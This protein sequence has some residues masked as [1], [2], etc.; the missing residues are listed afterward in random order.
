MTGLSKDKF[1]SQP[2]LI[3]MGTPGFAIPALK[4]LIDRGYEIL[5][6]VTQPDRPK[7]RGRRLAAPPVKE[8]A[9]AHRIKVLQPEKA[10]DD[11]FCDLIRKMDPDLIIVV[12][13]GQI[14][15]KNFLAI[16]KWGVINIH[17]SLLPKYRGA[18]PIQWAILNN[19]SKTGLT[20]M[21]MDEGLDTGPIL[22]QTELAILKDETAG[23]LHDRLSLLAGDMIV[24][25]L[26]DM[27]NSHVKEVLQDDSLA[28][29]ASKIERSDSL[30]D[31]NQTAN[32]ISC[33]IRALDPRPGAYTLLDGKEI[34]LFSSTVLDEGGLDGVPGRVVR[35]TEEGIH[36][37]AGQGIIGIREIQY[38]GKKR[39]SIADFLR[40]FSL[41]EGTILGK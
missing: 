25:T 23:Q 26:T 18:A 41:S 28:T 22:F 16:P 30:I 32:K 34:K 15:K 7:G 38:P 3:F 24:K 14:L 19:E 4:A 8:L 9:V 10:S 13:F 6:V 37:E 39:L 40:G 35:H 11:Q 1:P 21:R 5:T 20:V 2:R 31:W 17:A 33:L 36:V 29:Y 27:G 12:A